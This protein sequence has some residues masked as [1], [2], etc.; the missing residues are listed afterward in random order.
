MKYLF[1]LMKKD[2]EKTKENF[3][4][5]KYGG[6]LWYLLG[7]Y[8]KDLYILAVFAFFVAALAL[9][10]PFIIK[11]IIDSLLELD[12]TN[13]AEMITLVMVMF[14]VNR[15]VSNIIYYFD[16][17]GIGLLINVESNFPVRAQ[18][19]MLHLSLSYLLLKDR[20]A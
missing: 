15:A 7:S 11:L 10:D 14:L 9:I 6:D 8:K 19:K 20:N 1:N 4:L 12:S 2:K 17:R 18:E 3:S 5:L 13:L 16:R